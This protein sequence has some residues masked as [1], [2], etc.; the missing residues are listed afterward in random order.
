MKLMLI[1]FAALLLA[2]LGAGFFGFRWL[3][4][5]NRRRATR[6]DEIFA[7]LIRRSL[8][9]NNGITETRMT[10]E[11]LAKDIER[12][13]AEDAASFEAFQREL[14]NRLECLDGGAADGTMEFEE[15]VRNLLA[16]AAG[17]VPGVEV[18]L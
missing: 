5:Q 14:W 16:Y 17:K 9:A 12:A 2:N 4:R 8:D 18:S 7:G 13:R 6:Q 10:L 15:G 1:L 3:D 11:A